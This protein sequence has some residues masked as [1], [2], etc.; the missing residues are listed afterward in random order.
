MIDIFSPKRP[1]D[2]HR[3]VVDARSAIDCAGGSV[4]RSPPV[5]TPKRFVSSAIGVG[6]GPAR[7]ATGPN[8]TVASRIGG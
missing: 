7:R 3:I 5:R 1:Q 8:P 4:A 2:Q 6:V